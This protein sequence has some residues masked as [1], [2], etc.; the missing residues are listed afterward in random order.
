M[1]DTALKTQLAGYLEY[2]QHPIELVAS[3]DASAKSDEIRALL[4]ELASLSPRIVTRADGH[5]ARR[6]SLSVGRPGE[7]ARIRFAGVPMG[8]EFTSMV[9]AL[10]HTGGHPP[11]VDAETI[12][13]IRALEGPLHFETYIA[14]SC[15]NCP[16]VVQALNLMAALNPRI[17]S[18]MIDGA[19]FQSEVDA[20][21]IMAVPSVMLNG[22]PFAQGRMSLSDILARLAPGSHD[23]DAKALN[24]KDPFDVLVIGG[25]PAGAAAALYAARKGLATGLVAERFGGQVQDTQGIEN[26]LSVPHTEGPTLAEAMARHVRAYEVDIMERQRVEAL[27]P[28]QTLHRVRL[29]NGATL[30]ARSVVLAPGARWRELKVPGEQTYKTRGVCFCPHCDGPLFRG[31]RV[32]VIGGGNSGVEAAID[33]A[34]TASHVHLLEF[35]EALRA[36]AVLQSRLGSLP[37]V[38]VI[39][40]AQITEVIGDGD[41]VVGLAYRERGSGEMRHIDLDGLFVQIGLLPDTGWLQGSVALSS[42]GEIEVD[43]HG[44][45]SQP[46]IFAAGDATT[47]PYKQI[48]TAMGDG[49]KASLAAFDYLIRRPIAAPQRESVR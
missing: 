40:H 18:V 44:R 4:A 35:D 43:T 15:H 47:A 14:L 22:E 32:A 17:E 34:H 39:T 27:I 13:R 8:H 28:G 19:L 42:R 9:L 2:L 29:A 45:T 21:K 3:L 10:L 36:D 20:R 46:G 48:I 37:N 6:P 25:G 23:G 5:D 49:A 12:E 7:S 1:L 24:A 31:K 26:L 16:D 38:T 33:L 41:K 30:S 11:K